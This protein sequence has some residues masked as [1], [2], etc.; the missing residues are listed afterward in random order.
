MP[1]RAYILRLVDPLLDE[2]MAEASA[3]M[4]VGPRASGKTTTASRRARTIVKLDAEA[5]AT[6]FIADPDAALRDLAEPTL[7]DEWQMAPG[8]FGAAR[9]AVD[10]DA[11]PN[12]FYLVG[13]V[14]AEIDTDV[15]PG[16]GRFMRVPMYPMTQREF[17]GRASGRP[18]FDRLAAGERLTVPADPPDLR[19]YIELAARSGFPRAA[20]TSSTRTRRMWLKSYLDDLLTHDV[21][22]LEDSATRK[23][24][25]GRLRA[26]FEAYALN[27]AGVPEH[28]AVFDAAGITRT[29]AVVYETLLTRLLIVDQ[30]PA[31]ATNRLSRLIHAPK[32]YVID[33]ALAMAVLRLSVDGVMSDGDMLGRMLDTFVAA[34]LR[35][36][37]AVAECEPRLFH[38][39]THGGRQEIDI[40]AEL[41]GGRVIAI[42]IKASS[43]PRP[44]DAR[45]LVWLREELGDRF[46]CGV[47][48]HTGPRS[49]D[50]GDRIVAAPIAAIWG[51]AS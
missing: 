22:D 8:V 46:V 39:R 47:V 40:L 51:E 35:P 15:W 1:G 21:E 3:V 31:W 33:P 5:E 13:S 45:H 36:E 16:T 38:L 9:R 26:Y 48:F 42:E 43:A 23:R 34:Q 25:S 17:T 44:A 20:F 50:L 4:V 49:F 18:L 10:A 24:D 37:A 41:G 2:L 19:G 28:K 27:S 14:R 12:R 30:L 32:R 6:A 7:L 29:S 11:R